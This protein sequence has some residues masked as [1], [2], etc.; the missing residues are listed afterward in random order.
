MSFAQL[1]YVP[2]AAGGHLFL[3]GGRAAW[4]LFVRFINAPI[5]A[6]LIILMVTG[7]VMS[8]ANAL[9]FQSGPAQRTAETS[10]EEVAEAEPVVPQPAP[11]RIIAPA[12][13]EIAALPAPE[14][15]ARRTDIARPVSGLPTEA[16]GNQD[17]FELQRRLAALGHFGGEID[18]YYG[19][20]TAA[21]IRSFEALKG[22][23]QAGAMTEEIVA[24]V[25][26]AANEDSF[27][28]AAIRDNAAVPSAEIVQASP[29]TAREDPLTEIA[30]RAAA[31]S[32]SVV[33]ALEPERN[34]MVATI[35]R[36]LSRLGFLQGDVDGV[37]GEATAKAIRN[38]EVYYN[39]KVTGEISPELVDL[40]MA[41]G[42]L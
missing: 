26:K 28:T 18:G 31:P 4:W 35:Q 24:A 5:S 33:P 6:S 9:Y 41:A 20:Q 19:P 3:S 17:V 21:A 25:A 29:E 30:R 27:A 40:L 32:A 12:S 11:L 8:F 7:T 34:E 1:S 10:I 36:G 37:A 39:Y 14:P 22:L 15:V 13:S 16:V 38:F 42:G 23:P 2:V